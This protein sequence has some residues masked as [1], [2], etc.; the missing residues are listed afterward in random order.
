[1]GAFQRVL[2]SWCMPAC[3][4]EGVSSAVSVWTASHSQVPFSR[5]NR[6]KAPQSRKLTVI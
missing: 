5:H 4:G 3:L 2:T 1:M 6:R